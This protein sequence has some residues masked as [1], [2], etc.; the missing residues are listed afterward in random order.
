MCAS[1][2]T[3]ADR[4]HADR[5]TQVLL[6]LSLSTQSD[7]AHAVAVGRRLLDSVRTAA[8]CGGDPVRLCVS[9][10]VWGGGGL[11]LHECPLLLLCREGMRAIG[12]GITARIVPYFSD[13]VGDIDSFRGGFAL[14]ANCRALDA[15][16][17]KHSSTLLSSFGFADDLAYET[18]RC[19][20]PLTE[21]KPLGI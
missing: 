20:R 14:A 9:E 13:S 1:L 17:G 12:G 8:R 19:T 5:I 4:T 2:I 21:S 11:A 6:R 18:V 16:T 3:G 7:A 10:Y 15:L